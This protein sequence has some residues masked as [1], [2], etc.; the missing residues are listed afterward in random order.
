MTS[1]IT[2]DVND[3]ESLGNSNSPCYSLP[4]T[5]ED[6]YIPY[7]ACLEESVADYRAGGYHP[8]KIG[9]IYTSD[10][11][12][13]KV[14]HKLGWGHFS[15]VWLCVSLI[16]GDYV[17]MKIVKL[18]SNY[19]DAARDEINILKILQGQDEDDVGYHNLERLKTN[20]VNLLD[21]FLICGPNGKHLVMVFELMGENLLHLVY[22]LRARRLVHDS[23]DFSAA[24]FPMK[25]MKLIMKQILLS[26]QYM[27]QKGVVHTDLKPENILLAY[28]GR[29]PHP[30]G[31]NHQGPAKFQ[32]LPSNPLK[33]HFD[34]LENIQLNVKIADFG[35]ATHSHL[36]FTNNIQTRQYRAPEII[37]KYKCWGALADVWSIG[38]LA[39]ELLTGDYLFEPKDGASFSKDEDHL[40]QIIELIG[41]FPSEDYLLKCELLSAYFKDSRNMRNITSLKFWPLKNVLVEKYKFNPDNDD[42]NLLC[43]FISKCLKFN[44]EERYDCGS[45]LDHPWLRDSAKYDKQ[46]CEA[47]P[48]HNLEVVGFTCEE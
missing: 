18:G 30:S 7:E 44:L 17:A 4:Q 9:D 29:M 13:Y 21:N 32:I 19:S 3:Q 24:L 16:T 6:G 20:I 12:R 26:V 27:H 2:C 23:V 11:S 41:Q 48:N 8:V 35:N 5:D 34:R 14:I 36:H 45:L 25:M 39:F 43:D 28:H 15:T 46:E 1:A 31:L 47:L 10:L 42:V 33:V 40:A 37:L 22:N 38:C